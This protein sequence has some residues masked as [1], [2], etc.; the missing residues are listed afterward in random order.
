MGHFCPPGSGSGSTGPIESGSNPDPTPCKKQLKI[1]KNV[2]YKSV[3]ELLFIFHTYIFNFAASGKPCYS[4]WR[5]PRR[6]RAVTAPTQTPSTTRRRRG[7]TPPPPAWSTTNSS[8]STSTKMWN[9]GTRAWRWKRAA[10]SC[11]RLLRRARASAAIRSARR[12]TSLAA[13]TNRSGSR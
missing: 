11:R 9:R 13:P 5:M 7:G 4:N 1:L 10:S 12:W 3:L 2:F 8:S 6:P